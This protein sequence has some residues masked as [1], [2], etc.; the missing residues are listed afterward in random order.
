MATNVLYEQAMA[1]H[2][3]GLSIFPVAS[4]KRPAKVNGRRM[5]WKQFQTEPPTRAQVKAWYSSG[6]FD[7]VAIAGGSA[8][9]GGPGQYLAILD[10]DENAEEVFP[11]WLEIVNGTFGDVAWP[12]NQTGKGYHVGF[13]SPLPIGNITLAAN[14][15]GEKLIETRGHGG[16]IVAPPT[17][18]AE[19]GKR[20]R[21]IDGSW[22]AIPVLT[23]DEATQLLDICRIFDERP[24][25]SANGT[26]AATT[27]ASKR[28]SAATVAI[29][30]PTDDRTRYI[31]AALDEGSTWKAWNAAAGISAD[32]HRH[33]WQDAILSTV[34]DGGHYA[35]A[36]VMADESAD[37]AKWQAIIT[38]ARLEEFKQRE[39][40]KAAAAAT[41]S[42]NKSIFIIAK[43]LA[44]MGYSAGEVEAAARTAAAANGYLAEHSA[45]EFNATVNSGIKAGRAEPWQLPPLDTA[46]M[47]RKR[48]ARKKP[49]ANGATNRTPH[50]RHP[51]KPMATNEAQSHDDSKP[52]VAFNRTDLGNARRLIHR[53]GHDLLYVHAWKR[54]L[55]WDG[56]RWQIDENGQVNRLAR[57]TVRDIYATAARIDD[58]A[59][60][61]ALA[62]WAM[63]SENRTR[64]AN[65]VELARDEAEVVADVG[66]IDSHPWFLTVANG[67][68]N[69]ATG[70]LMPHERGHLITKKIGV[71]YRPEAQAPTWL[72]FLHRVMGGDDEMVAFLQRAVGYTLTGSTREQVMF[73][74]YGSGANGKST[75][76]NALAEMMDEHYQKTPTDTLMAKHHSGS[77]TND[78]AALAGKRMVVAAE[79]EQGKRLAESLVKDLTGGDAITARFLYANSFSFTP[80]FKLWMYG[81]HKPQVRGT[82]DGIWRR[83][84]LIPFTQT[85]T[86]AERDVNLSAKLAAEREGILAWAVAGCRQWG[87]HGLAIPSPV[88]AATESY[89]AEM[90]ILA[91]FMGECCTE[92]EDEVAPATQLFNAF[93]QWA[94]VNGEADSTQRTFGFRLSDRGFT[95]KR[96]S[97]GTVYVGI[98]LSNYGRQL[99][100]DWENQAG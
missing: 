97:S 64:L 99:A 13:R 33:Q 84:K 55:V 67:T 83:I 69:L 75:F 73:F 98:G 8:S 54:W 76:I 30:S 66:K 35:T 87:E 20:Y 50:T 36:L 80:A 47:K 62:K 48:A 94:K 4:D 14:A 59:E 85:I 5:L 7:G 51:G 81:N 41:G 77:A 3:G 43:E 92:G 2:Q 40:D 29:P 53:H 58:E 31:K 74:M 11:A 32:S 27:I 25:A 39:V 49:S 88:A 65:M 21:V 93:R 26:H 86:E 18:H 96:R 46:K 42:R 63:R 6:R 37:T 22:N 57:E 91:D 19:S 15:A 56:T 28:E 95:K 23:E 12:I 78:V 61:K 44:K 9:G 17:T 24:T 100:D 34:V 82:D 71:A 38:A 79:V 1:Y 16:Y 72:A 60:R 45:T 70:E 90:D 89:R 68:L 52:S 10:F